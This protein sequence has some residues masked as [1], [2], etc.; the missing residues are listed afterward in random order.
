MQPLITDWKPN[1]LSSSWIFSGYSANVTTILIFDVRAGLTGVFGVPLSV[2]SFVATSGL[3]GETQ[4]Q[5]S[6]VTFTNEFVPGVLKATPSVHG[7]QGGFATVAVASAGA[8]MLWDLDMRRTIDA[9]VVNGRV[10]P[11]TTASHSSIPSVQL[12]AGD[13]TVYVHSRQS[14]SGYSTLYF[15]LYDAVYG[16]Q[17]TPVT[18][19]F[20][21]SLTP[22]LLLASTFVG[23]AVVN[24]TFDTVASPDAGVFFSAVLTLPPSVPVVACVTAG[25]VIPPSTDTL[26]RSSFAVTGVASRQSVQLVLA[27]HFIGTFELA[28]TLT[29]TDGVSVSLPTQQTLAVAVLPST[30]PPLASW[31][32]TSATKTMDT[33]S[34]LLFLVDNT[35][36]WVAVHSIMPR[37]RRTYEIT[38]P[39]SAVLQRSDTASSY[40]ANATTAAPGVRWLLSPQYDYGTLA[41]QL[42]ATVARIVTWNNASARTAVS[43]S[44]HLRR[45]QLQVLPTAQAPQLDIIAPYRNAQWGPW[46]L[47]ANDTMMFTLQASVVDPA[48]TLTVRWT[49]PFCASIRFNESML[50]LWS[51]N[52]TLILPPGYIQHPIQV[53]IKLVAGAYGRG[54]M[55]IVAQSNSSRTGDSQEKSLTLPLDVHPVAVPPTLTLRTGAPSYLEGSVVRLPVSVEGH[56]PLEFLSLVCTVSP[57]QAV[58]S[59]PSWAPG[60]TV[61]SLPLVAIWDGTLLVTCIA[62]AQIR[63]EVNPFSV[64]TSE[65]A[66]AFFVLP[67]AHAPIL[68]VAPQQYALVD[69]WMPLPILQSALATTRTPTVDVWSMQLQAPANV[70]YV[71][72]NSSNGTVRANTTGGIDVFNLEPT[73]NVSVMV[74]TAGRGGVVPVVLRSINYVPATN[75]T[76]TT[77]QTIALNF[78]GTSLT[79][80]HPIVNEGTPLTAILN[81]FT[82]PQA[83]ILAS[84]LCNDTAQV[85]LPGSLLV[86]PRT[87]QPLNTFTAS[88]KRDYIDRGDRTL[89][90]WAQLAT[91]DAWYMQTPRPSVTV[92][93]RNIDVS[94]LVIVGPTK[95]GQLQLTVGV[96]GAADTFTIELATIPFAPVA[97]T[98]SST[99]AGLIVAPSYMVLTEATWNR[100]QTV[101][102]Y[103]VPGM[104]TDGTYTV[105]SIELVVSSD[106]A[107][108]AA[109][110]PLD[111]AVAILNTADMTPAP[112]LQ[113]ATF[114]STGA[115]LTVLFTRAV[116]LSGLLPLQVPCAS[117]FDTT[118]AGFGTLPKC[119]WVTTA[120][121]SVVLGAAATVVPGSRC[122][123]LGGLKST[124]TSSLSMGDMYVLVQPPLNPPTPRVVVSGP[125]SLGA[126]D[127][128]VLDAT[129]TTG[130]GGRPITWAWVCIVVATQ[131]PCGGS[132]A[133][134]ASSDQVL[135]VPSAEISSN[136]TISITLTCT[137]FFGISGSSGPI[138][139]TKAAQPL[140]TVYIAGPSALSATR[141]STVSFIGVAEASSCA[142]VS[143]SS[144]LSVSW[145]LLGSPMPT[146]QSRN[147]RQLLWPPRSLG[148]G[149]YTVIL[150]A[151]SPRS[152]TNSASVTLTIVPSPLVAAIVGGTSST[153]GTGVDLLL[154]GSSSYDPDS[155][156]TALRFAW[157]VTDATTGRRILSVPSVAAPTVPKASLAPNSTLLVA[158]AVTDSATARVATATMTIFVQSG[159]PPTTT[160][161]PVVQAKLNVNTKIVLQGK[162]TST[163]NSALTGRWTIVGDADGTMAAQ[164]FAV[165]DSS[166]AMALRANTLL[167]GAAY[168]LV[169][170]GSDQFGQ[171]SVATVSFTT[172]EPPTSG[173]VVVT[174]TTGV[175][176][177]TDF[178]LSSLNWV[179]AGAPFL[180]AFKYIVGSP[181]AANAV[182]IALGDYSVTTSC[183][184]TLPPGDAIDGTITIVGYVID[185]FG[186]VAKAYATIQ[187][188]ALSLSTTATQ[189]LIHEQATALASN[190][191]TAE[192]ARIF[193][194]VNQYASVLVA[195]LPNPAATA[196]ATTVV[197]CPT[198]IADEVCSG[199]GECTGRPLGC[200]PANLNCVGT[201]TCTDG[202]FGSN[203]ATSAAA[204]ASHQTIITSLLSAMSAAGAIAN[205]TTEGLEQQCAAVASIAVS[206]DLLTP[207]Q[208][209]QA[210]ALV[211]SALAPGSSALLSSTAF[212]AIGLS[213]SSLLGAALTSTASRRLSAA[214][215]AAHI[216]SVVDALAAALLIPALPDEAPAIMTL[217]NLQLSV[218]R[219][220]PS[221]LASGVEVSLPLTQEQQHQQYTA[222]IVSLPATLPLATVCTQAIDVHAKQYRPNVYAS[223]DSSSLQSSIL[224]LDLF[225]DYANTAAIVTHLPAPAPIVAPPAPTG[226]HV[227]VDGR[228]E[229]VEASCT[230][231]SATT[232]ISCNGSANYTVEYT[233]PRLLPTPRCQY[234]DTTAGSWATDGCSVL[235]EDFNYITCACDHLTDFSTQIV[236][237]YDAVRIHVT[238]TLETQPTA[239]S[240]AANAT[241]LVTL[242]TLCVLYAVALRY[243][244]KWDASDA[245]THFKTMKTWREKGRVVT[246]PP[247]LYTPPTFL[248][249]PTRS[250]RIRAFLHSVWSSVKANHKLLGTYFTYDPQFTRPQRL[251]IVF[252]AAMSELLLNAVLYR[253]RQLQPTVGSMLV[254]GVVAS[255]CMLPVT[256][257]F[258]VLFKKSGARQSFT[259]RYQLECD[260]AVVEVQVNAYGHPVDESKYQ[261][262]HREHQEAIDA[263]PERDCQVLLAHLSRNG[264]VDATGVPSLAGAVSTAAYLVLYNGTTDTTD[265]AGVLVAK[266]PPVKSWGFLR[267]VKVAIE[268]PPS[269][270]SPRD[271]SLPELP[272]ENILAMWGKTTVRE[273]LRGIDPALLSPGALR[274]AEVCLE[275]IDGLLAAD[276]AF[277]DDEVLRVCRS[278]AAWVHLVVGSARSYLADS[279]AILQR[280]AF[281][282][283]NAKLDL[284]EAQAMAAQARAAAVAQWH[285]EHPAR[286]HWRRARRAIIRTVDAKTTVTVTHASSQLLAAQ[287]RLVQARAHDARERRRQLQLVAAQQRALVNQLA[288]L[289]R[290]KKRYQLYCE[291]QRATQLAQLPLHERQMF[292]AEEA[293]LQKLTAPARLLYNSVLRR[294]TDRVSSPVFPPWVHHVLAALCY[295]VVAFALYFIVLFS[296]L[297]GASV[298]LHW[299]GSVAAGLA[300]THVVSEPVGILLKVGVLPL[301]ATALLSGSGVLEQLSA[302]TVAWGTAAV[303]GVAGVTRLRRKPPPV[304]T[305][306]P[307]ASDKP[308]P[309]V[310]DEALQKVRTTQDAKATPTPAALA[311]AL[312]DAADATYAQ[313]WAVHR[314]ASSAQ[315]PEASPQA[316]PARPGAPVVEIPP[317]DSDNGLFP[318]GV[319]ASSALPHYK[320]DTPSSIASMCR[321]GCGAKVRTKKLDEHETTKCPRR[322]VPC[323]AC[324]VAVPFEALAEHECAQSPAKG[325][326]LPPL[327]K[328]PKVLAPKTT[329][330]LANAVTPAQPGEV[331]RVAKSTIAHRE[332]VSAQIDQVVKESAAAAKPSL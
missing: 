169:F 257:A 317:G 320:P 189:Q 45:L 24:V 298:A 212:A 190:A 213:V 171:S 69:R 60:D 330:V 102:V 59:S 78:V 206:A 152:G 266:A 123:A 32:L 131:Q 73:T 164:L 141:S 56:S 221:A 183:T 149:V 108:Y 19:Y 17:I 197:T 185:A 71:H 247:R 155:E 91:F 274:D 252:T 44:N 30:L 232:E 196:T 6:L 105:A 265:A 254:S 241:I 314:A 27:K 111:A 194:L 23:T 68:A 207:A 146:S 125:R 270:Q 297:V 325:M 208:T 199:N 5:L 39:N 260:T 289:E 161:A 231:V 138:I 159:T 173:S 160:I 66:A 14:F 83:L 118:T 188:A 195:T 264:L 151:S 115:R 226:S 327:Q 101:A 326:K 287:R 26:Q 235:S 10:L 121:I 228:P 147:P 86:Y 31:V 145:A 55:T 42:S 275:R 117:V 9:V 97:L 98:L 143:V 168:T 70:F 11:I 79:T 322:L 304:V 174:P 4:V 250:A 109:L 303:I 25:N 312:D 246:V 135:R 35:D 2:K 243:C 186:A 263:L 72:A 53:A 214:D 276:A 172:N 85:T 22:P 249:A 293:K 154:D 129:A 114:D 139:V 52:S 242:A 137:N 157:N 219:R 77:S 203:C 255:V 181:T 311:T 282:V 7:L 64:A 244:I 51:K 116:Y 21:P 90:C 33:I 301:L 200:T 328:R 74:I 36:A 41:M 89:Q 3:F 280:M 286:W 300:L 82:P 277:A 332:D 34:P 209:T 37:Q 142:A 67:I 307:A 144:A 323:P 92:T 166:W 229:T 201:C 65:A 12:P 324:S 309:T 103:A 211:A 158:L 305:P 215:P 122:P 150:S 16:F 177:T 120:S 75:T 262:L 253:L 222:G 192:P 290:W 278:V 130:A 224:G 299:V 220:L 238:A 294:Q 291:A 210:L 296:L 318:D 284:L 258:I 187:V 80:A 191:S 176:L 271:G 285:S 267:A 128:L 245:L 46:A 49:C 269:V 96:G 163:V 100:P 223:A 156:A 292:E 184:T 57:A 167:P 136:A 126:C 240:V 182:E 279:Q 259:V 15:V 107:L 62:T 40:I 38:V 234:W 170:T 331:M 202:W 61:L 133:L 132:F 1:V 124:A 162:V 268:R 95:G 218:Q 179:G 119:M 47:Y 251:M 134:V 18:A 230:G 140:P 302:E 148:Y 175:A 93:V 153:V 180:F 237:A 306:I 205:P 288:G 256:I 315:E 310:T 104:A 178:T 110:P 113:A 20:Q 88:T 295:G 273:Q 261:I 321:L 112:R 165:P 308:M 43:S 316:P 48:S 106:D 54:V 225:C 84:F 29:T 81:L 272:K 248:L 28:I 281:N 94:D 58:K 76:A 87:Y 216:T 50:L 13:I 239:A 63:I 236:Q 227:C 8:P 127:D 233:C 313:H 193:N 217:P 283:E 99:R 198:S 319:L 204:L 329:M